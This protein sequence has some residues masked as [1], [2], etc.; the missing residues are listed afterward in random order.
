MKACLEKSFSTFD[1]EKHF[2]ISFVPTC[3]A[4]T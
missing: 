3:G 4:R 1:P 2:F